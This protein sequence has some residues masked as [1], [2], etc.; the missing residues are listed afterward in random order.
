MLNFNG[1]NIGFTKFCQEN[2]KKK[3]QKYLCP[4]AFCTGP[5]Y[6]VNVHNF[7]RGHFSRCC[8]PKALCES[9]AS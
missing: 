4:M 1:N 2:V 9:R 3:L 8:F 5:Y 6:I 7:D